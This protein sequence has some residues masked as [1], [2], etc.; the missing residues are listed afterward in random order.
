MG[1]GTNWYQIGNK[2]CYMP[3]VS[4]V[5]VKKMS[6][7]TDLKVSTLACKCV[8]YRLQHHAKWG[9]HGIEF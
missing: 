6:M 2:T 4:K 9:L 5:Y 7:L 3:K 8:F 1:L